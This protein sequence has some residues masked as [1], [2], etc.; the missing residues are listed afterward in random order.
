MAEPH[1]PVPHTRASVVREGA[2]EIRELLDLVECASLIDRAKT[3]GMKDLAQAYGGSLRDC[4]RAELDDPR[5][6]A[7]V[8]ARLQPIIPR[9]VVVGNGTVPFGIKKSAEL[10]G[11][12]RPVGCNPHWRI[13]C[14]PGRGHFGPH[15]DGDFVE[16]PDR[17]S[18]LT[19]NGYLNPLPRGQGGATR[20]LKD[21][22]PMY[23]DELGRHIAPP[24]A[25]EY[26]VHPDEA[27]MATVF[28]HDLLHDGEELVEG[29]PHKWIFRTDV[30]FERL[31]GTGS[32]RE[33]SD[34]QQ[35][36]RQMLAEAER[37]EAE[38]PQRAMQL[39]RGAFK[40]DPALEDS[41]RAS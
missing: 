38:D 41:T 14:Y 30:I 37:L 31:P 39:Y 29:C 19:V 26:S 11:T 20:F 25:V 3:V 2:W 40:L 1:Q 9:E 32:Q 16:T 15:R 36:A 33:F 6:A 24:G 22:T 5:L 28:F 34:Q 7:R 23:Q 35:R 17:R 13:A 8:F 10:E 18:L 4:L 12:W 27:G 21:D